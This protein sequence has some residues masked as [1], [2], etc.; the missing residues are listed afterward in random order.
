MKNTTR[1]VRKLM[2]CFQKDMDKKRYLFSPDLNA[3]K[4]LHKLE[5]HFCASHTDIKERGRSAGKSSQLVAELDHLLNI[6][7]THID[8]MSA[9]NFSLHNVLEFFLA[10]YGPCLELYLSTWSVKEAAARSLRNLYD[11]KMFGSMHGIFDYR[12]KST[13]SEAFHLIEPCFFDIEFTKNHSKVILIEYS[14]R[15]ITILTSAN[16]SNNPRIEVGYV[17]LQQDV[18]NF[19]KGWMREVFNGKKVY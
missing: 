10:K 5:Q 12:I 3:E 7:K 17:S 13:D 4:R 18:F 19:H 16:M 9:G 8:F 6:G 2:N 14:D 15:V 1:C 11:K